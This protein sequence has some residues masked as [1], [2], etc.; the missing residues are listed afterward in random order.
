M[1][2]KSIGIFVEIILIKNVMGPLS[3]LSTLNKKI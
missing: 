3:A 1:K 2:Q